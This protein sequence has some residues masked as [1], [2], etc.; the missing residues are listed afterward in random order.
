MAFKK[1]RE[2]KAKHGT[3]TANDGSERASW[4]TIGRIMYDDKEDRYSVYINPSRLADAA[5][6][7]TPD[8]Y[9]Y[10]KLSAFEPRTDAKKPYQEK[11]RDNL[12]QDVVE[13]SL[14]QVI[15]DDIPF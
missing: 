14:S 8:E 3:Y 1:F 9:G 4:S 10:I 12:N 2:L 11:P 6:S 13:Q 5:P 15:D 7:L